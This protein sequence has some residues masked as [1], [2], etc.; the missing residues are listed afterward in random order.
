LRSIPAVRLIFDARLLRLVRTVPRPVELRARPL[1]VLAPRLVPR[2]A[3]C[4]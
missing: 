4:Y 2:V 1:L 3:A